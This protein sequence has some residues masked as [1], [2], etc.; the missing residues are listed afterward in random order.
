MKHKI[1]FNKR[2][3]VL[4]IFALFVGMAVMST[5]IASAQTAQTP[6]KAAVNPKIDSALAEVLQ[7]ASGG[8]SAQSIQAEASQ[9]GIPFQGNA[10][11]VIIETTSPAS[12]LVGIVSALSGG[13]VVSQSRNYIELLVPLNNQPL[14]ALIQLA[15]VTGIAYIRAPLAPQALVTSEG[16]NLTG[17][18]TFQGN[19]FNG[20][21][22]KI[23]VIDLG[24][25]G[26]SLAQSQ[27]EL[28]VN[29]LRFDFSGTGLESSTSHGTAVAEIVHDMAPNA[30]LYLM[31]ISD[32][33]DLENA[34]D[35]AIRQGVDIIN[36]AVGWFNTS[37]YDG[38]GPIVSNVTRARQS[39]ILWVNAAGNYAQRHWQGVAFDNNSNGWAE[40]Q[41]QEGL[42]LTA[43]AGQSINVFMTWRD[44]PTTSQD[45]DLFITNSSGTIFASSERLQNGTQPP[46]ENIFFTAPTSGTFQ[47]RVRPLGVTS[48]KEL[49]IFNL[50]Q[51]ITPVVSSGSI[52]TPAD[53][54][55]A[56]AVGAVNQ[57]QWTTGPIQVFSSQGP[58]TDG[59]SKPDIVGPDSVSV[60]TSQFNPFAGTS[61]AAPH[62]AGAAALLLSEN[63]TLSAASL[64]A[65]LRSD[66]IPIGSATQFGSGRLSLTSQPTGRPDLRIFNP[67]FSP[68]NPNV[69]Q[70]VTITAQITNLGQV[71]SGQFLVQLTDQFGNTSQQLASLGPNGST[72]VTFNRQLF[73][74]GQVVTL[75]V[76]PFNQIDETDEGNNST[77]I[78]ISSQQVQ[79]PDLIVE[80][81][82][83][84]PSNPQVGSLLTYDITVR[85]Q[86]SAS[87]GFFFVELS[88]SQGQDRRSVSGLAA[89]ATARITLQRSLTLS[90]ET[91]FVSVDIFNQ[92]TES[93]ENNNVS[94]INVTGS[95]ATP[96]GIDIQTDRT[97]YQLND[98][99]DVDFTLNADGFVRIFVVNSLGQVSS[100]YPNGGSG[101]LQAGSYDVGQLLNSSLQ[102]SSP[103]GV[104]HIHAVTTDTQVSFTIGNQ[105]NASWVNPTTFQNELISRIQGAGVGIDYDLDVA[106]ISVGQPLAPTIDV[107]TNRTNYSVGEQIQVSF[108]TNTDGYVRIFRLD[109]T[110][111]VTTLFPTSGS[112]FLSGGSY[113]LAQL[114]GSNPV[115]GAPGTSE[116]IHAVIT[117]VQIS[118][119]LGN[120][121]NPSWTN[122]ATFQNEL[123]NRI[124]SS[125][126]S[127]QFNFDVQTIS[128]SAPQS[129]TIS[130]STDR[131]NYSVGDPLL[132]SFN[133]STSGYVRIFNVDPNGAV[134]T[135]YPTSGQGFLSAGSYNLSQLVGF[136]YTAS[137]PAGTQNIHAVI[138]DVQITYG[139]GNASNPSWTNPTTFQNELQNR[140][141]SSNG[142]AQFDF[143]LAPISVSQAVPLS[144]DVNTNQNAYTIGQNAQ[145]TFTIND[146]GYVR[147]YDVDANGTVF[148]LY[149][150]SGDGFLS[151]GTYNVGQLIG[152]NLTV[153]GPAG[154]EHIHG[155]IT[156]QEVAFGVGNQTNA[157]WTSPG[158]F[159]SRLQQSILATNPGMDSAFDV[160]AITIIG[161]ANQPPIASF[162]YSPTNPIVNTTVTLNGTGSSDPDGFITSYAWTVTG[163]STIN[164][165]GPTFQVT[166]ASVR[167]FTVT[168]TVTDNQGATAS[169]TQTITVTG[170]GGSAPQTEDEMGI[171]IRSLSSGQYRVTVQGDENWTQDHDFTVRMR[172]SD[173]SNNVFGFISRSI[174]EVGNATDN[175]PA[176]DNRNLVLRGAAQ[177]GRIEYTISVRNPAAI[178][179]DTEFNLAFNDGQVE[180]GAHEIP[181]FVVINNEVIQVEPRENVTGEFSLLGNNGQLL[182]LVKSNTSVC[183]SAARQCTPL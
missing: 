27:G 89:G 182:P 79:Q 73:A 25:S 39:G 104:K 158:T 72:S 30:Q 124:L 32:E 18:G 181:I 92:V 85:N 156:S 103:S 152:S 154:T 68:P 12:F 173:T 65:K 94:T 35:E 149:P 128:T 15:N 41:G 88:D 148:T 179:F 151:A 169:T 86:G 167:D 121:S 107:N 6:D 153:S 8:V 1:T 36:H 70:N 23:A 171:Y 57:S 108:T 60:S 176:F 77:Q 102:V 53:S 45:Y 130:V 150:Q 144:I 140:I 82:L 164:G 84:T 40:F 28:P 3:I 112:G 59:R 119:G 19:G 50:N 178:W 10:V 55:S 29:A 110:G 132:V 115:A 63:P 101:F 49:A 71:S 87:A 51:D 96:Q 62:V 20:A 100:L 127:A 46:T 165:S 159:Q 75:T 5:G 17:A 126:G 13:T 16:V 69:G 76:D 170:T 74:N 114:V 118:Y 113:N 133:T 80:S 90:P 31:K 61:A 78:T 81:I 37:F 137:T 93:N 162:T 38:T 52:V 83:Y 64:D 160:Q 147:I 177:D 136:N 2:L 109:S 43:Q 172:M 99:I 183:N 22:T 98:L 47:I 91:V 131:S 97:T 138:T 145:I 21:G 106:S 139:L 48:P 120:A 146:S 14:N 42:T 141:L 168:L 58:T 157:S 66:A 105:T 117:D 163:S 54:S 44:W 155:V 135:L 166:F 111:S 9:N 11:K 123:Q 116:N 4:A 34:V 24:F 122:P 129:P 175:S 180:S 143:D 134:T 161:S 125:N 67:S 174:N 26:L 7:L 95:V 142:S 56:L 33:V